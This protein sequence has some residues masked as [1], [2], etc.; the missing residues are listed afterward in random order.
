MSPTPFSRLLA[1]LAPADGGFTV[2]ATDDWR[3]GRTLYGGVAAALCLAAVERSV[4]GLAPLRSA[5]VSFIGPAVG[6]VELRPSLLRQGKTAAFVGCD[7]VSEGKVA[8]RTVFCF[9]APRAS[10]HARSSAPAP[11]DMPRPED[12]APFFPPT[13]GPAFAQHFDMRLAGGARPVSAAEPD[14]WIWGKHRDPDAPAGALALLA[15][16]DAPPP[17]AMSAFTGLGMIS[18]M[19]WMVD[20][21]DQ[22]ALAA[23]GW[24]LLRSTA[25]TIAEGYSAQTMTVWHEDGRAV[26]A[27]RQCVAVFV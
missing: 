3:Q 23:P 15:L 13:F 17:A 20:V 2:A 16:A 8:T 10:A 4:S 24:R 11:A 12:C 1:S 22:G 9:G 18:T 5:Q 26:L 7:L 19:T 25:E 27:G 14:V 21:L 6:T